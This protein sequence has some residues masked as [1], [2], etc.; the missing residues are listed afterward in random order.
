[1]KVLDKNNMLLAN[2]ASIFG[3]FEASTKLI[4]QLSSTAPVSRRSVL[5]SAQKDL[6]KRVAWE[7][8]GGRSW[9]TGEFVPYDEAILHHI[10]HDSTTGLTLLNSL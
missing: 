4:S 8:T 10:L 1:M 3:N 2:A 5:S 6:V 7:M 9:L